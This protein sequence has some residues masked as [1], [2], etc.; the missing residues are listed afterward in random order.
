MAVMMPDLQLPSKLHR[1]F[2][3]TKLYYLE[4]CVSEQL[5][6]GRWQCSRRDLNLW[7]LKC[8]SDAFPR[9]YQAT[10]LMQIRSEGFFFKRT[11]IDITNVISMCCKQL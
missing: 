4:M 6:Q 10:Q 9:C 7:L 3:S 1:P 11:Q 2:T 5:V 8:K